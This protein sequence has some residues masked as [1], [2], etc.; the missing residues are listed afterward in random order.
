MNVVKVKQGDCV[1]W[2]SIPLLLLC[3]SDPS[4]PPASWDLIADNDTILLPNN[5]EHIF[6]YVMN[7]LLGCDLAIIRCY[8][9]L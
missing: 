5:E 3:K 7:I 6:A 8:L 9:C 1:V 4:Q 2:W